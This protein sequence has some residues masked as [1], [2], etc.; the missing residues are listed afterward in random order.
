MISVVRHARENGIPFLGICL[1]FQM[2]TVEFARHVCN[3]A[4]ANSAEM[5]KGTPYPVVGLLPEQIRLFSG[6]GCPVCVTP[7]SDIDLAIALSRQEDVILVTFGDMMRVPAGLGS[8]ADAKATRAYA[9]LP[10]QVA[11]RL[12]VLLGL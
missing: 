3:L 9:I 6:P 10:S 8:L 5:D 12:R 2:A 4:N 11:E 7:N 1:G